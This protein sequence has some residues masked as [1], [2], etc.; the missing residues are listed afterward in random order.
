MGMDAGPDR[1]QAQAV[2]GQEQVFHGGG[3]V[4]HPVAG[5][6]LL[7]QVR[8]DD[9][10]ERRLKD[11]LDVRMQPRHGVKDCTVVDHHEPPGLGIARA[12]GH[13]GRFQDIPDHFLRH[14]P[15]L[16]LPDAA[17]RAQGFHYLHSISPCCACRRIVYL[18]HLF[19]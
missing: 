12:G 5:E 18:E 9:D 16:E 19:C 4:L 3:A 1:A 6:L 7:G 10:A 11:H 15:V 14:G 13:H 17:P 8:A 2:D